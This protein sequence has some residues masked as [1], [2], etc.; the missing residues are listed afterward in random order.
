MVRHGV[1]EATAFLIESALIDCLPPPL[2]NAVSG[3]GSDLGRARLD[4]LE[5]RY[6]APDSTKDSKNEIADGNDGST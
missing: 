6:G 1:D 3:Y 5:R 2:T 4:E